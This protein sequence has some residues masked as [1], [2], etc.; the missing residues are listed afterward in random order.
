MRAKELRIGN[1]V[2]YQGKP[3]KIV[4]ITEEHPDIDY[5]TLDYLD[6]GDIEPIPLTEELLLGCGFE[7]YGGENLYHNQLNKLEAYK[8]PM[9]DG[10]GIGLSGCYTLPHI[11]HLHQLQNLYFTLTGKELEVKL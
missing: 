2:L 11:K 3:K 4:G 1:I 6:W 7:K 10:Y 9:K 8:H 5:L